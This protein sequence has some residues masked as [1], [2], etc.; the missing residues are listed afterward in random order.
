MA[1]S[2][3]NASDPRRSPTYPQRVNLSQRPALEATLRSWDDRIE[4]A[5]HELPAKPDRAAAERLLIQMNGA[6]DQI[7]DAVRRMPMEIGDLYAEDHHRLEE[8]AHALERLFAQ[9]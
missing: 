3:P 4:R 5:R 1:Q 7:A 2:T 6:R 9:W 8:A